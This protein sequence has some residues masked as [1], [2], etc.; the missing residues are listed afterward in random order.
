MKYV[1]M[2]LVLALSG[3]CFGQVRV[4]AHNKIIAGKIVH[5]QT[6]T[7]SNPNRNTSN[8]VSKGKSFVVANNRNVVHGPGVLY[9]NKADLVANIH[10]EIARNKIR[11]GHTN[12]KLKTTITRKCK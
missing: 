4:Q 11:D 3:T 2:V 6:F 7:R 9:R 10:A 1:S 8:I 12:F 5:V